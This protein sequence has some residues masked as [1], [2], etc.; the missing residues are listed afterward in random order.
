MTLQINLHD[1]HTILFVI[2][3]SHHFLEVSLHKIIKSDI[4]LNISHLHPSNTSDPMHFP[5]ALNSNNN[6]V[7]RTTLCCMMLPYKNPGN[8]KLGITTCSCIDITSLKTFMRNRLVELT[9]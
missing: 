8:E 2:Y 7:Q 1:Y 3:L 6:R 4:T 9:K 5:I